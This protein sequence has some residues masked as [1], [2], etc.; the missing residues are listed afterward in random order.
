MRKRLFL[1]LALVLYVSASLA[2]I[3]VEELLDI[4][5]K[6]SP[7]ITDLSETRYNSFVDNL[8]SS[9]DGP[10]WS[11][12]VQGAGV[13]FSENLN[14]VSYQLPSLDV[15]FTT[16]DTGSLSFDAR[17][18]VGSISFSSD[19]DFKAGG[20]E[21]GLHGGVGKTYQF[22]SWDD[23]DYSSS[24][25]ETLAAIEYDNSILQ[26][27]MDFLTDIRD[28][29]AL[30]ID[31]VDP[32]M[33]AGASA[34][35]YYSDLESGVITEDSP[36]GIRRDTEV[37]IKTAAARQSLEAYYEKR[38][39]VA[40]K[41][42]LEEVE[43]LGI[44]S[45]AKY[46]LE[47]DPIGGG[48]YE[49]HGKYL[50][51]LSIRQQIEEKT[52]TSSSL[53]LRAGLDPRITFIDS[54]KHE[55]SGISGDISAS[56]STG[57]LSLDLSVSTGYSYNHTTGESSWNGPVITI[58]GSWSNT[59]QVLS[60]AEIARL[61]SL[62]TTGTTFNREAYEKVLRDLSN[63]AL[64]KEIIEIGRLETSLADA[65]A[66]YNEAL[67]AYNAKVDELKKEI[68][69]F[70]ND[71]ELFLIQYDGQTRLSQR[72]RE[73]YE[74]GKITIDEYL[75]ADTART[76][77]EIGLLIRNINSHILYNRIRMLQK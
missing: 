50:E 6:R 10:S 76:E 16:P 66:V 32:V 23:T 64:Q 71:Y 51:M 39:E 74:E 41:Y 21:I 11:I 75:E 52:G 35:K 37:Q 27:E 43:S 55:T 15:S 31:S 5:L 67:A 69:D 13:S 8:L 49:V 7:A 42:G 4:A 33:E 65:S 68:R 34:A 22:R 9:L 30:S 63:N 40:E 17:A 53:S 19:N 12:G 18:N 57:N 60:D 28:L 29:L 1:F 61:K 24:W 38:A 46:E 44:D 77:S 20:F 54:L 47:I 56:Y 72:M 59:P 73:L 25:A 2:A 70:N 14:G 58:G 3:S 62:Y 26:F 45:A 48:N 36:E